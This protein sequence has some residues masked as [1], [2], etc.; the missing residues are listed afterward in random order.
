MIKDAP[1]MGKFFG[2]QQEDICVIPRPVQFNSENPV[3]MMIICAN[4]ILSRMRAGYGRGSG[5][6]L[7]LGTTLL[8]LMM[9]LLKGDIEEEVLRPKLVEVVRQTVT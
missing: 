2:E 4:D 9:H 5:L 6:Q 8:E 3:P 7:L 1:D